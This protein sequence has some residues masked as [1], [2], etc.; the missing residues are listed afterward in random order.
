MMVAVVMT[1]LAGFICLIWAS[2]H[3]KLEIERRSGFQLTPD[4]PGPPSPP[5]KLSVLVAGKDEE[6]NIEPCLRS[7]MMQEYPNL[8]IIVCDDRSEDATGEI[9]DRLAGQDERIRAIH[10]TELPAGWTGKNHA[11]HKAS[12]LAEGEYLLFIDADCRQLSS[13]SLAVAMQLMIDRKAGFL[14]LLPNLEM[15]GFWENV[16]QPIGSGILMVWFEPDKVNNPRKPH[17]YANGAFMLLRRNV[18]DAIGGHAA[19][20]DVMQE[21]MTMGQLAKKKQLGLS[22]ARS[23]GLYTVRMY[24]SFGQIMRGWTRIFYGSFPNMGRLTL[25]LILILMTGIFPYITAAVGLW[26]A[27]PG[28]FGGSWSWWRVCG[29]LGCVTIGLQL[30]LMARFYRLIHVRWELFWTYPLGSLLTAWTIIRAMLKHLP[31]AKI[32]WKGTTYDNK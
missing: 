17:A 6:A 21:D 28:F 23:S 2:R 30:T 3:V 25:S 27:E 13:R 12:Q 15:K 16:V 7:L 4:Y 32:T 19:V 31:G 22:V 10:V 24:T 8:E 11:M 9:I 29:V 5:P 14:C 26:R 1:L 18:Y 20:H